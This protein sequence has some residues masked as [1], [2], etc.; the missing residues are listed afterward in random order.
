MFL[1][2]VNKFP[3]SAPSLQC[4]EAL[5]EC[6]ESSACM[7]LQAAYNRQC[8]ATLNYNEKCTKSCADAYTNF[9]KVCF[10]YLYAFCTVDVRFQSDGRWYSTTIFTY[11][12]IQYTCTIFLNSIPFSNFP[13]KCNTGSHPDSSPI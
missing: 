5:S 2:R 6:R 9:I 13:H 10:L 12:N 3:T 4:L 11:S 1:T 8:G 7:E